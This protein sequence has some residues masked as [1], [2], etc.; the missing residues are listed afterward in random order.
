MLLDWYKQQQKPAHDAQ[1][2]FSHQQQHQQQPNE[3]QPR[4]TPADGQQQVTT[5]RCGESGLTELEQGRGTAMQSPQD[6]CARDQAK[7]PQ[8]HVSIKGELAEQQSRTEHDSSSNPLTTLQPVLQS[9]EED[10]AANVQ[11]AFAKLH[12]YRL[13]AS[14]QRYIEGK[15]I[16]YGLSSPADV[17]EAL[18]FDSIQGLPQLP[19]LQWGDTALATDYDAALP[20]FKQALPWF[21]GALKYYQLEGWVTE[22]C[23]I[24]FEMSNLYRCVDSPQSSCGDRKQNYRGDGINSTRSE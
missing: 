2:S 16:E 20:L 10:I 14:H 21:R 7:Q 24:L 15:D 5:Q 1:A 18:C 3:E 23:H 12:L 19:S 9:L 6:D 11:L 17:P 22:H 4:T 8:L 13:V